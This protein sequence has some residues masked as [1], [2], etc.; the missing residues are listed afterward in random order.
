MAPTDSRAQKLWRSFDQKDGYRRARELAGLFRAA[1]V[2][3]QSRTKIYPAEDEKFNLVLRRIV[4]GL[5][6]HHGLATAV[7]DQFVQCEEMRYVVPPVFENEFS[8]HTIA[9]DFITYGFTA[10]D[11]EKVKFVWLIRFSKHIVFIGR[12][13]NASSDA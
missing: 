10:L 1:T 3:G 8:W 12:V 9:Q 5:S 6:H 7:P 4:R 13:R 2:E 11:D